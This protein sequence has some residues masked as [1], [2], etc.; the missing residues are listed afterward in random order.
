MPSSGEAE[1]QSSVPS[2]QASIHT[3]KKAQMR[4]HH[5]AEIMGFAWA[6]YTQIGAFYMPSWSFLSDSDCIIFH[7]LGGK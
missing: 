7:Q 5:E 1:F 4:L 6:S 2:K 3:Q